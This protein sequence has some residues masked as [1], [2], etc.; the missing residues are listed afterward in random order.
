MNNFF[1]LSLTADLLGRDFVQQAILAAALLGLLAGLIG[2]FVVMRQ[3]SFAVHGSSELSLT[4]AAAALLAGANVG[5][6]ALLGSV[7]AAVLFGVLGQRTK[8]R[9]SSIGVVMAFGLGLAVLFIH[10]YPGRTGT[11][12]A[13]LTGQIVGV[14]YSGLLMLVVVSMVVGAVLAAT[15]R[16]MLFA[17]VDPD[18]AEARGVP[19]RALGIVFAALVG[20]T[21]AQG[22]QIVGAL[23]VMSLL[24]TPAAAAA[25]ITS[26]P[27]RAI[28]LSIVFAE[29]AAIGGIMLSLAPGV[30]I[31][32][33]VTMIAVAIYLLC[34]LVGRYRYA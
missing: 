16:P 22:V 30:P 10:L 24:I 34:R 13:L 28:A 26:S 23:L 9:D 29:I 3:M 15:Y 32:V 27:A 4:G 20:L 17:T 7:V 11:N 2:P 19:V 12:F 25:R 14:G 1:D 5:T 31:S 33:F 21:A 6:G 8:D 18:V